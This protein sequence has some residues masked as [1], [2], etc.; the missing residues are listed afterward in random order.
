HEDGIWCVY[1]SNPT[2]DGTE[3]LV[4]GSVDNTTKI[5]SWSDGLSMLDL[6]ATLEG[7]QLGVVSVATDPTAKILASSGLDGNIRLWDL[8]SGSFIKSIDRG[9]M[10]VW[11][12]VFTPDGRYLATGSHGG[13]INLY[14]IE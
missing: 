7:H 8:E 9:P 12:V 6:R 3:Y 10:D 13:K 14:E 2:T 4:T 1:W 5:W 11:T